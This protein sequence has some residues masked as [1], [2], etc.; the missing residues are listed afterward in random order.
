MQLSVS[1]TS[2]S[3]R[4]TKGTSRET[5]EFQNRSSQTPPHEQSRFFRNLH[6]LHFY[7]AFGIVAFGWA[8]SRFLNFDCHH[9][10]PIWLAG[11][12]A[13]YNLDR[14]I[15]DPADALNTPER[16]RHYAPLRKM[17]TLIVAISTGAIF[18]IPIF[19]R[20]WPL[21]LFVL[22][23]GF[24][25]LNYSVPLIGF[26]FKDIPFVKTLFPPSLLTA[27]YFVPPLLE[28]RAFPATFLPA[29]AWTW[30]VLLFNMI[31]CDQRDLK[32]DRAAGI[33]TLPVLLGP[34]PTSRV[35]FLLLVLM[36]TLGPGKSWLIAIYGGGLLLALRKPRNEAFY[37]WWVEGI[38]FIPAL[39]LL[40]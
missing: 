20:D 28:L 17:G 26:R 9:Y 19:R 29:I 32:G 18:F 27:A 15:I 6:A 39:T 7:G 37:E 31:L 2:F 8:L 36:T 1:R 22:I 35:L 24:F 30:C 40:G 5:S 23:G 4:N 34:G 10:L 13:I 11:A 14:L 25:S 33:R 12:L 16:S 21:F 3:R 38:L